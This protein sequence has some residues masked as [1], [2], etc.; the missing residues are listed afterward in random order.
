VDDLGKN[1]LNGTLSE[2]PSGIRLFCNEVAC[3][4]KE[5]CNGK[6][7]QAANIYPVIEAAGSNG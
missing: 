3:R 6:Q 4:S 7:L 2:S 5:N 1:L